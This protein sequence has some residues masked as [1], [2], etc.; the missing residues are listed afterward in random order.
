MDTKLKET[1]LK[2]GI[3]KPESLKIDIVDESPADA[4]KNMEVYNHFNDL[5]LKTVGKRK[6]G[7]SI[8]VTGEMRAFFDEKHRTVCMEYWRKQ[9]S[10]FDMVL[11]LPKKYNATAIGVL[12]RNMGRYL[13]KPWKTHLAVLDLIG[14]GFVNLFGMREREG[15]HYTVADDKYVQLQSKH[16]ANEEEKMVWILESEELNKI[17]LSKAKKIE[18]KSDY[19]SPIQFKELTT[20]LSGP[21]AL[22]VL[23]SLHDHGEMQ[24]DELSKKFEGNDFFQKECFEILKAIKFIQE[25]KKYFKITESGKEYLKLFR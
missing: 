16:K 1:L 23:F 8:H 20:T 9:K 22:N 11:Y 12:L 14:G 13:S 6:P 17:L 4:Q 24:I 7:P 18:S 10:R 15:I 21:G 19:I 2:V 3:D 5:L 25:E